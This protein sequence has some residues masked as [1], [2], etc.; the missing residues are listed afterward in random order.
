MTTR[1]HSYNSLVSVQMSMCPTLSF[2]QLGG[3]LQCVYSYYSI[4]QVA[5]RYFRLIN[6][7]F[8]TLMLYIVHYS[9]VSNIC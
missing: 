3:Y 8:S 2:R 1:S 6:S 7:I 5:L 4:Q 9:V